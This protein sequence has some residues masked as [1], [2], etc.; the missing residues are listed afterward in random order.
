M[1]RIKKKISVS[2]EYDVYN[3]AAIIA[4]LQK[5]NKLIPDLFKI[6]RQTILKRMK[7]VFLN[8]GLDKSDYSIRYDNEQYDLAIE[9]FPEL[10]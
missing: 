10:Q 9:L 6:N 3:V 1:S 8:Y 5:D 7:D 4:M 2:F